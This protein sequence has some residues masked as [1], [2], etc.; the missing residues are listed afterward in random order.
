MEKYDLQNVLLFICMTGK[1]TQNI[2]VNLTVSLQTTPH[3]GVLQSSIQGPLLLSSL[4]CLPL[5]L[6]LMKFAFS[7]YV[8]FNNKN[9]EVIL[10]CSTGPCNTQH[11]NLVTLTPYVK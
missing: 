5:G 1:L 4:Y 3:N 10:L 7:F 6:I 8:M 9:T 2:A 11:I